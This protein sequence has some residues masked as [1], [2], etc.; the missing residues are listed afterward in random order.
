[1]NMKQ[2]VRGVALLLGSVLLSQPALAQE[3]VIG[4][5]ALPGV[6][7]RSA[8]DRFTPRPV[9]LRAT[10]QGPVVGEVLVVSPWTQNSSGGCEGLAVGV[11][12]PRTATVQPLPTLEYT[13]E[14]PGAVVLE[15]RGMWF[16][17]RLAE[18][19][20]WLAAAAQD[21]YHSL[22]QLLDDGL[23]YLTDAWSGHVAAS[24]GSAGRPTK[25][26]RV[27]AEQPVRVRRASREKEG[28]WFLVDIM[29]HSPCN[30]DT[31]PTVVDQ[32]W[33]PAHGRGDRPTLWFYSRGC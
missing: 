14:Q 3:R 8:C 16:R 12:V 6:F 13:Y 23:T 4:L 22:E 30:G 21:E 31:E 1:M 10:P 27:A 20:A 25:L 15:R 7:G 5:L 17:V 19:S 29:S 32:G 2:L 24:P 18:G 11:R 28:L 33:V 9:E 26:A